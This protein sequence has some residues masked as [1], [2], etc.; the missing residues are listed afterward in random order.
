MRKDRHRRRIWH[1][2]RCVV[3]GSAITCHQLHEFVGK[4]NYEGNAHT[5]CEVCWRYDP[6]LEGSGDPKSV[7]MHHATPEFCDCVGLPAHGAL[8]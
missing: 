7:Y 2:T 1:T 6:Y 3:R 5:G 8:V 4:W